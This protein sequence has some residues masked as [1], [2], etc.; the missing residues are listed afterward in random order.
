MAKIIGIIVIL[1]SVLGGGGNQG[2]GGVL[3]SVL[4]GLFGNK[5]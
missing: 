5:K 2:A 3:G 1:G 4:G